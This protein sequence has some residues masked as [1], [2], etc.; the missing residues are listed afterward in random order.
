MDGC[1]VIRGNSRRLPEVAGRNSG[2]LT[3]PRSPEGM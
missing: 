2:A 1:A 3:L